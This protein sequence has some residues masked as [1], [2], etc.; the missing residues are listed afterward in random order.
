M[1][2]GRTPN[3]L[4]DCHFYF[5]STCVK[6]RECEYRHCFKALGK[7][8]VCSKWRFNQCDRVDCHFRHSNIVV[9]RQTIICHFEKTKEGCKK[10]HCPFSH[11]EPAEKR[12]AKFEN[13]PTE[14]W[15]L[16]IAISQLAI[17]EKERAELKVRT[18]TPARPK[19]DTLPKSVNDTATGYRKEK[20]TTPKRKV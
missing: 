14:E 19:Q 1:E 5:N 3:R 4:N 10:V 11:N 7:E 13:L 20:K 16:P 12:I 8:K 15:I 17:T 2:V 18:E 6:G 9:K